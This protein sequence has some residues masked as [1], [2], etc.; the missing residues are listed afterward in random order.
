MLKLQTERLFSLIE[1]FKDEEQIT[2]NEEWKLKMALA[3]CQEY[4]DARPFLL[5][6]EMGG[7]LRLAPGA[8]GFLTE[9]C[10]I[11]VG[12]VAH[13]IIEEGIS[14]SVVDRL[15]H[16]AYSE[17]VAEVEDVS[18]L[19][20]TETL[21]EAIVYKLHTLAHYLLD[22]NLCMKEQS[23]PVEKDTCLQVSLFTSNYDEA[24]FL[25]ICAREIHVNH[26]RK[27][28]LTALFTAVLNDNEFAFRQLLKRA[29]ILIEGRFASW[30]L[31]ELQSTKPSVI[32]LLKAKVQHESYVLPVEA[33]GLGFPSVWLSDNNRSRLLQRVERLS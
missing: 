31:I 18:T 5:L 33:N 22:N 24:L 3:E 17:F 15:L 6:N 7:R 4:P 26:A 10:I 27:N 12:L 32:A 8:Q 19:S 23:P 11:E 2:P 9:A 16:I 25:K 30:R 29:D 20:F 13:L 14:A 28:G 21:R 1:Q